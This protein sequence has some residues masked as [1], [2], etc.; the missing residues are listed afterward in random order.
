MEMMYSFPF[1]SI[2]FVLLY[3]NFSLGSVFCL[4]NPFCNE[5]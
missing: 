4:F 5:L 1:L 3:K 2:E